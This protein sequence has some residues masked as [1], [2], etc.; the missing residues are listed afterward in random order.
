[1]IF[2]PPLARLEL[3]VLA[4]LK[5]NK[6]LFGII[7]LGILAFALPITLLLIRD[8]QNLRGSAAAPDQLESESGVL[9]S[10]G[11]TKQTSTSASGGQFVRFARNINSPTPT[12]SASKPT[13]TLDKLKAFPTAYGGG[14]STKG[15]RG[16]IV[17][18]VN[19]LDYDAPLSYVPASGDREA[20]YM[21]GIDAALED[22]SIG[23]RY[24]I[25][26][27]SGTI[28]ANLPFTYDRDDPN[29]ISRWGQGIFRNTPNSGFITV[30]GQTAPEGGITLYRTFIQMDRQQEMIF[31]HLRVRTYLLRG[32]GDPIGDDMLT[33]PISIGS[34]QVIIDHFSAS[35]GGD[36]GL[37]LG[38]WSPDYP[39]LNM[40]AQWNTVLDSATSMFAV[41]GSANEDASWDV[42]DNVSWFY[43]LSMSSHRTPN[44][45]GGNS[46]YSIEVQN[47]VFQTNASR[48]GNIATGKPSVNYINNYYD[49]ID[50]NGIIQNKVQTA[51]TPSIHASGNFY[52]TNSGTVLSGAQGEDN[53]KIFGYFFTSEPL[54]SYMFTS[55]NK[56]GDIPDTAPL[57][58]ALE[59]KEKVLSKVGANRF[60]KDDGTRVTYRDSFDSL[61][62]D[63]FSKR[64]GFNNDWSGF[65]LPNIP[66][67]KRPSGYYKTIIGIPEWFV[68]KHGITDK[69]QVIKDWDFGEYKVV[70]TAGYPAIEMYAAWVAG[71]F[72]EL[73]GI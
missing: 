23:P 16:G 57:Y 43:N 60:I 36:K 64:Q 6:T 34:K 1:L 71:D 27:V 49:V 54:P 55:K 33:T 62:V 58:S 11:V 29:Y 20:Y 32:S 26:D 42:A 22:T 24:I 10:T 48:F 4:K 19:T 35:H 66:S 14:A 51:Y 65:V 39:H 52:R 44:S 41:D 3:A 13:L 30:L 68:I 50:Q 45:G 56:Y 70:N 31:R 53:S 28:N 40:T 25:F 8:T 21:G 47:N 18:L 2:Y 17:V 61:A 67:T 38:D 69:D 7:F 73:L 9:S 37:I 72:E 5:S 12:P 59:A 15:G 63:R 46:Q